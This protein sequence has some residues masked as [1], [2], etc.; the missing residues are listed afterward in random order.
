MSRGHET[1]K[2]D[3]TE[4]GRSRT[5]A[6]SHSVPAGRPSEA[7]PPDDGMGATIVGNDDLEATVVGNT[8]EDSTP[9]ARSDPAPPSPA[10]KAA[11]TKAAGNATPAAAASQASSSGGSASGKV[12]QLGDFKLVR[13]LGQGGMGTVYLARQVSLDREVALKT[14]TGELAKRE[15]FVQRFLREARSMARLHH[16]N[17][18]QV[19]AADSF[20]GIHYAAIEFIDG[21]S[22]QD[23]MDSLKQLSIGDALHI[24]LV[25][26][27]ALQ[28]A[29]AKNMIHRDI[30]PDNILVTSQGVVKVADFGLAKAVDED[31]SMTQSGTGLGTPLYMAPEQARNAKHVDQRSDIYALGCTLYYFLTGQLPF[32]GSNTIELLTSKEKGGYTSARKLNREIPERLDLMIDRMMA[33]EPEQRYADYDELIEHLSSLGLASDCLS[34]IEGAVP[35][36]GGGGASSV[37][38][39]A[40]GGSTARP[41]GMTRQPKAIPIREQAE[42][43]G[44]AM[45]E[46]WQVRFTNR[47]GKLTVSELTRLQIEKGIRGEMLDLKTK[48]RRNSGEDWLPLAQF[49]EFSSLISARAT[50][51]RAN[52]RGREMSEIYAQLDRQQYWRKKL[53]WVRNLFSG[54]KGLIGL[55]LWLGLVF[56]GGYAAIVYGIPWIRQMFAN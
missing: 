27:D 20:R 54:V 29:H 49:S 40:A 31:V 15:D 52:S 35:A 36:R 17:V 4:P 33:R 55:I 8:A 19:Y 24:V 23:W 14:L 7:G 21:Q 26:A 25:C 6:G 43:A 38:R 34:F 11:K 42:P 10:P 46:K 53:A 28:H 44:D 45:Q 47:Q 16:P 1:G 56:G 18:V 32:T 39:S 5:T 3:G 2:S 50:R 37:V 41:S 48:A 51:E 30:K 13:K 9:E 12:K 22:M